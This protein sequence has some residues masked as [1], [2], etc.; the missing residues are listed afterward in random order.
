MDLREADQ[1]LDYE[2]ATDGARLTL[3]NSAHG[4]AV[5]YTWSADTRTL[6]CQKTGQ[7]QSTCLKDCDS[8]AAT[9]FQNLPQTSMSQPFLPATNSMGKLD[10]DLA[11]IVNLSWKCSRPVAGSKTRTD[12]AQ[13]LRIVLRNSPQP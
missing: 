1:V 7:P 6:I 10:L 12:A 13:N 8:W 3:T 11:R 4:I 5:E 2:T 9:F